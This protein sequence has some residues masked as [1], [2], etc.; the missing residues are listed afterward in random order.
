MKLTREQIET[1]T[2]EDY[3][4]SQCRYLLSLLNVNYIDWNAVSIGKNPINLVLNL[5][6]DIVPDF[7]EPLPEETE[8]TVL[9]NA[10]MDIYYNYGVKVIFDKST[11]DFWTAPTKFL[12]DTIDRETEIDIVEILEYLELNGDTE[13][14]KN[15]NEFIHGVTAKFLG[16]TQSFLTA[17]QVQEFKKS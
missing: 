7:D 10:I 13:A 5:C 2:T 14:R 1:T 16:F 3:R 9:E 17:L 8:T 12:V 4:M 15:Y 11:D 6:T